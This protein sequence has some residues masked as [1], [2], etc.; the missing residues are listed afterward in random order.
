MFPV[1]LGLLH[2]LSASVQLQKGTM[3]LLRAAVPK[4]K[5]NNTEEYKTQIQEVIV[6]HMLNKTLCAIHKPQ[7]IAKLLN[8]IKYRM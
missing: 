3:G 4:T 6:S 8:I 1:R 5:Q 7:A 2:N